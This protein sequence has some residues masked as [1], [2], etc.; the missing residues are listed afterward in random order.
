MKRTPGAPFRRTH[1]RETRRGGCFRAGRAAAFWWLPRVCGA[2][3][4]DQRPSVCWRRPG[5]WMR[6]RCPTVVRPCWPARVRSFSSLRPALSTRSCRFRRFRGRERSLW[7]SGTGRCGRRRID[8]SLRRSW[9]V[10]SKFWD[11]TRAWP[12][13]GH[14]SSIT[15][16]ASGMPDSPRCRTTRN[17]ER[18]SGTS[19]TACPPP[20]PGLSAAPTI[21][22]G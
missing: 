17:P 12:P 9:T 1:S 6:F 21:F 18:A 4:P 2:W 16:A 3:R 22:C 15:R 14:C 7:W 19:G 13:A 10:P 5:W 8:T 11:R 20:T